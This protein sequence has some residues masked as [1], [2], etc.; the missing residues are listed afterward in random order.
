MGT[1]ESAPQATDVKE[2][3]PTIG[4]IHSR[5]ILLEILSYSFDQ[6]DGKYFLCQISHS[7][8][9]FLVYNSK[10]LLRILK[11]NKIKPI[12]I[13]SPQYFLRFGE[14]KNP[15][16]NENIELNGFTLFQLGQL[17]RLLGS[18]KLKKFN[19]H[20]LVLQQSS[21]EEE[22]LWVNRYEFQFKEMTITSLYEVVQ[23]R[24]LL[25]EGK[26]GV[27]MLKIIDERSDLE[28]AVKQIEEL[29]IVADFK[30]V[31][32]THLCLKMQGDNSTIETYLKYLRP[33]EKD[34][35]L[36]VEMY[37]VDD[38][39]LKRIIEIIKRLQIKPSTFVLILQHSN[40][41]LITMF[42]QT[43]IAH[44]Q[45]IKL[46]YFRQDYFPILNVD[47]Q[48]REQI[49]DEALQQFT[50]NFNN[51]VKLNESEVN[52]NVNKFFESYKMFK[53]L[54]IKRFLIE[55]NNED[56]DLENNLQKLQKKPIDIEMKGEIVLN[57]THV[58]NQIQTF[59][60]ELLDLVL[61]KFPNIFIL[62]IN[63]NQATTFKCSEVTHL[64]EYQELSNLER[65][66]ICFH[67]PLNI[68]VYMK[69][70]GKVRGTLKYFRI[71]SI[72]TSYQRGYQRETAPIQS[73]LSLLEPLKQSTIIETIK[74]VGLDY[75]L[76]PKEIP[77]L[78]TFPLLTKLTL[79][80]YDAPSL[81]QLLKQQFN[82]SLVNLQYLTLLQEIPGLEEAIGGPHKSLRTV[83][84]SKMTGYIKYSYVT[85]EET[86]KIVEGKVYGFRFYAPFELPKAY[87]GH[88][89]DAILF[90]LKTELKKYAT[91]F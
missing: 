12:K 83:S 11:Q 44:T 9:T 42:S 18:K 80:F 82:H 20:S 15:I 3:G 87:Q 52:M 2:K 89:P 33:R 30:F 19:F 8:V 5:F 49:D 31:K 34:G 10:Y 1:I 75:S 43:K 84:Y 21:I 23:L 38:K 39:E 73:P 7:T 53:K 65:L 76:K 28:E 36:T 35:T 47:S 81:Q 57:E 50:Q 46:N 85:L 51:Y 69:L 79:D 90:D 74:I 27:H 62:T 61:T 55:I 4:K 63:E 37:Q 68:P 56:F 88:C 78:G 70:L 60:G 45:Y 16:Y 77:L 48:G 24:E 64:L 66:I 59:M 41:E 32:V 26:S 54:G 58:H 29:A 17:Q 71:G 72:I 67:S 25:K 13:D 86:L 14:K 40:Q 6:R 91:P 22:N